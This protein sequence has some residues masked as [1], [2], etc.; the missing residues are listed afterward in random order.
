MASRIKENPKAFCTYIKSMRV[1][2]ERVGPLKD[3]GGHL[4][5]E[6]EEMD[7]VLNEY[8]ASVF[9]KEKDLVDDESGK[10]C[11]DSLNHVE[12]KKEEVLGFLRNIQ[13]DKTPGPDAIYP[14][15]LREAREEIAG[16][17]REIFVSSLATGEVAEDWRIANVVPLFKKGSKSNPGNYRPYISGREIIG[18]DSSRQDLFPLGNKWMY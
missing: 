7:E 14:R 17:L 12:I 3:K 6:P 10:G 1:A 13:V 16:A 11:V 18:E 5:V 4:C 8:F 9:T 15:I 2:R